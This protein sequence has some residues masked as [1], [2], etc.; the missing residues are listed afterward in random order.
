MATD[1]DGSQSEK[2]MIRRLI[3]KPKGVMLI[4]TL[5]LLG[6]LWFMVLGSATYSVNSMRA[7]SGGLA[8]EQSLWAAESGAAYGVALL[9]EDP[10]ASPPKGALEL[11]K[12]GSRFSLRF[13]SGREAPVE[14]PDDA[15]YVESI[16]QFDQGPQRKV[17][18][19]LQPNKSNK[20]LFNYSIFTNSLNLT[21][22]SVIG[23]F[24]SNGS[25]RGKKGNVG[26]NS[27]RKG[28]I[29]LRGR[30]Q[31]NGQVDVGPKG[32]TLDQPKNP[33]K[34]NWGTNNVVWKAR[35][36]KTQGEFNLDQPLEFP[37][38]ESPS[39]GRRDIKVDRK[40]LDLRPGSYDDLKAAGRGEL[41]LYG[42]TYV[43]D[44]LRFSNGAKLS[45]VGNQQVTIYVKKR[46]DVKGKSFL[47]QSK[48]AKNLVFVV[49]EKASVR[50]RGRSTAFATI[51]A[52]KSKVSITGKSSLYGAVVTSKID[53]KNRSRVYYDE[54]LQK[55]PPAIKGVEGGS[56]GGGD[57]LTILSSQRF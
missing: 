44:D 18:V 17:C 12:S 8:S 23:S 5:G 22:R 24:N 49:D 21:G 52:P 7:S 34:P 30:S 43:F 45:V 42:G 29:R 53:V 36:T 46:L 56:P 13:L 50:I 6:V 47:N 51:Y 32:E 14:L 54:D 25:S 55:N 4:L 35:N 10:N 11:G 39:S 3:D 41:R 28:S 27:N 38:A 26:T 15:I 31:I 37:V 33:R 20:S 1:S 16:G 57:G 48:I 19:V 9:N 2:L 40:G